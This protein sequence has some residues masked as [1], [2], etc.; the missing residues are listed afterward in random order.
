MRPGQLSAL[1]SLPA[2]P[3]ATPSP[4]PF[5]LDPPHGLRVALSLAAEDAAALAPDAVGAVFSDDPDR[6]LWHVTSIRRAHAIAECRSLEAHRIARRLETAN[7]PRGMRFVLLFVQ[8]YGVNLQAVEIA[9][10]VN[11]KGGRA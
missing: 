8:G 6:D 10:A 1:A 2:T 11:S 9:P 4:P 3:T 7:P 5:A